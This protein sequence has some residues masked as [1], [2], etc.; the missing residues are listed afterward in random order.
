MAVL[1][2]C[3][4]DD[5]AVCMKILWGFAQAGYSDLNTGIRVWSNLMTPLIGVPQYS[6]FICRYI[7]RIINDVSLKW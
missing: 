1:R 2:N 4:E 3:F 6:P 7:S 5:E